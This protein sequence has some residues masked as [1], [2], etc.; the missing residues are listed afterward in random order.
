MAAVVP[1]D[2][3]I[4]LISCGTHSLPNYETFSANKDMEESPFTRWP[5][6]SPSFSYCVWSKTNKSASDTMLELQQY[7]LKNMVLFQ[8]SWKNHTVR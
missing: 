3:G 8:F 7:V 6:P 4:I 2:D 5:E 1:E